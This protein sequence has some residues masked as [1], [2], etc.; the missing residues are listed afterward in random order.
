MFLLLCLR[1]ILC[2][3]LQAVL[4]NRTILS[5]EFDWKL[6]EDVYPPPLPNVTSSRPPSPAWAVGGIRLVGC[7]LFVLLNTTR[8]VRTQCTDEAHALASYWLLPFSSPRT[9]V[10]VKFYF[11]ITFMFSAQLA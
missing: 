1:S 10:V 7:N 9:R 2:R 11:V 8:F 4:A 6:S 3:C 5:P